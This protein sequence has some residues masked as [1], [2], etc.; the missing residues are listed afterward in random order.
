MRRAV[1]AGSSATT[2]K[3]SSRGVY[4]RQPGRW[5]VDFRDHR[6]KVR[7]WLGTYHSEE[8]ARAA[9]DAFEVQLRASLSRDAVAPPSPPNARGGRGRVKI[10]QPALRASGRRKK[11][12]PED[13]ATATESQ[14]TTSASL[15]SEAPPSSSA[16]AVTPQNPPPLVVDPFLE[17]E[18][19]LAGDDV[20][21]GFGLAD[22]GHLPLPF[23]DGSMDFELSDSD[24]SLFDIG[25]T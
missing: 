1:A 10:Q 4:Q 23:L 21:F 20:H 8:E 9:Y 18:D 11:P 6:L 25:F 13:P 17:E 19:H 7:Q 24:L 5:S 22:L 2:K 15:S 12:Q 3:S 14:A 16:S